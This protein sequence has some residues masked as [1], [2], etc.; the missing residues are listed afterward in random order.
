MSDIKEFIDSFF[1]DSD[2]SEK[3]NLSKLYTD[4]PL[5]MTAA[6]MASFTP[7]KY[8]EMRLIAK[9][10]YVNQFKSYFDRD[11]R[12]F[13]EQAVFMETFEDEY[14][15]NYKIEIDDILFPT[16]ED[17]T[18][19]EL[20]V[21]FTWR[22]NFRKGQKS[23]TYKVFARL[24]SYELINMIGVGNAYEA[25][26]RL[27]IL[28][29]YC[30]SLNYGK[31]FDVDMDDIIHDFVVY[32][33]L[34]ASLLGDT[35]NN[36]FYKSAV[37]LKNYKQYTE[38]E[39]T[40]ALDNLSSYHIIKSRFYK[41]YTE[42]VEAVIYAVY[43]RLTGYYERNSSTS[44]VEKFIGKALHIYRKMF[45]YAVFYDKDKFKNSVYEINSME[46]YVCS[47]GIWHFETIDNTVKNRKN[48]KNMLR[49]IDVIMRKAYDF[50]PLKE[51]K[52]TK[53]YT[54]V[55]EDAVENLKLSKFEQ[56][57]KSIEIDVSKLKGIREAAEKIQKKLIVDLE[58]EKTEFL[59]NIYDSYD[60]IENNMDK[61]EHSIFKCDDF[62]VDITD[63]LLEESEREFL[64]QLLSGNDYRDF[65][66][67]RGIMLS[68]LVDS[69]NEKLY[70][71]IG[72][73]V[74][75]FNDDV[76][77]IIEDYQEDVRN[78]IYD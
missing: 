47:K 52:I 24:Y 46:R 42:D 57:K 34:D 26:E 19:K 53:L 78:L 67:D 61:S 66:K 64:K 44:L 76:P 49:A 8:R 74:I 60:Y 18:D 33:G 22:S 15:Y 1:K 31:M 36:I 4:E 9:R 45:G 3:E 50:S 39:L 43:D 56:N 41:K 29:A 25:Y 77:Q 32:R 69:I 35:Y 65:V 6:Q 30:K 11:S 21:Y 23:K 7:S 40:V 38:H 28:Q 62:I 71:E 37:I 75:E 73:T 27:R 54:K 58:E 51:E 48:V 16:Y 17:L 13:Y 5:L 68:I 14:K 2:I 12:I 59:E 10:F 63:R 20:R 72:D 55:I 70:E